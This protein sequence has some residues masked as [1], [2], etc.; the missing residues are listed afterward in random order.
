MKRRSGF[1]LIEL[2]V[3]IAIIAILAAILFPVFARA[4]E[5]ARASSCRSNLKQLATGIQM[6]VQDYDEVM[7][8]WSGCVATGYHDPANAQ[9]VWPD[10]TPKIVYWNVQINPYIKNDQVAMCPSTATRMSTPCGQTVANSYRSNYSLNQFAYGAG[11]AQFDSPSSTALVVEAQNHYFRQYCNRPDST[12]CNGAT[13]NGIQTPLNRHSETHNVAFM[14][15]HVK[16]LKTQLAGQNYHYHTQY[17]PVGT[18]TAGSD[19]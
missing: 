6:Y 15:G 12:C 9:G 10:G 1:T 7:I 14:D 3:V 13:V 18:N 2:L 17:H 16:A 5:A 4:R 19:L 11:L 8:G